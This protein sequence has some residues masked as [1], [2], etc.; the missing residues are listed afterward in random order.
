MSVESQTSKD[1]KVSKALP[2][3]YQ[4]SM[5]KYFWQASPLSSNKKDTIPKFLK[6]LKLLGDFSDNELRTLSKFFNVRSYSSD[7][8]LKCTPLLSSPLN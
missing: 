5:L 8:V 6:K 1:F 2:E 4:I 7:E 3:K